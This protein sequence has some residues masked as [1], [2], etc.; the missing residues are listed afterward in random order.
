[1]ALKNCKSSAT[2]PNLISYPM[3]KNLSKGTKETL[4]ALYNQIWIRDIFPDIW[5]TSIIVP[6][7][8]PG[9][10][11][12]DPINY[13]PISLIS[14]VSKILE[15][16]V[17][18]RLRWILETNN[19]L[20][21]HQNGCIRN[22][23]ILDS[24]A[25]IQHN[26]LKGFAS[27]EKVV[28]I[29]LDIEKAF[30][31]TWRHKVLLKLKEWDIKGRLFKYLEQFLY[32]R[33]IQVKVKNCLSSPYVLENGILQGSSLSSTLWNIVISDIIK[34]IP[35]L[36][37]YS[38]Y[39]DDIFL[40]MSHS[41]LK[42]IEQTLQTVLNSLVPW[43]KTNGSKFSEPKTKLIIFS[44]RKFKHKINLNFNGTNLQEC[45]EIKLLGMIMDFRLKWKNHI[46]YTKTRAIKATNILKILNN[47][48]NGISRQ[49]ALR[50]YKSYVRP[51]IEY[52][53]PVY[54]SAPKALLDKLEPVQNSAIRIATGAFKSS[55]IE[56]LLVDAG[57]PPLMFR[58]EYLSNNYMTKVLFNNQSPM[59]KIML[60]ISRFD[61]EVLFQN[62]TKPLSLWFYKNTDKFHDILS[63]LRL[64]NIPSPP[65]LLLYPKFDHLRIKSKK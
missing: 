10:N 27:K 47:R 3:L 28:A 4:L 44:K 46:S 40:Y 12:K 33:K 26:I 48:N 51:I 43:S 6:I 22:R 20:S 9:R 30:D 36:V 59:R 8:K 61:S 54:N 38:I 63:N 41:N 57:E 55:R 64:P 23:S 56:N 34:C 21:E 18:Y 17:N 58:R 37:K 45:N 15:K 62:E 14:C 35:V 31:L 19:L 29:S 49:V 65:W 60:T 24:P 50:L 53:A 25:V 1:M 5:K 52:G 11:P 39:V 42:Y 32:D 2:G 13:R 16:M 7:L